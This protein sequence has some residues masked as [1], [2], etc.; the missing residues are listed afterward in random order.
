MRPLGLKN[1]RD[2]PSG[3]TPD[4]PVNWRRLIGYLRPFVLLVIVGLLASVGSSA[5]SLV[6]PRVIGFVVDSVLNMG[7]TVRL[8]QITL[9]LIGVFLLRAATSFVETLSILYIGERIVYNLRLELYKHLQSLSLGFFTERRTGEL[10]SRLSNDVNGIQGALTNNLSMGV[11]QSL[12]LIG[13]VV[14]M[15]GINWR[16]ALFILFLI[17]ILLVIG[18]VFGGVLRRL[19]SRVNDEIAGAF[20]V[21]TEVLTSIREV[22]SFVRE[23]FEIGR[24]G[25]SM[26]RAFRLAI[27]L[28]RIR[29][30]F[31]SLIAFLGFASIALVLW[32]GGREVI[33]GRLTGG[34]L[35]AFII[36]GTSVA[37]SLGSL[38]GLYSSFQE[39]L[40]ATKRVFEILDT[41]PNVN[42]APNATRLSTVEGRITF[43]TVSFSYDARQEALREINLDIAPGEIVALVGPSGAGKSTMFNLIP[44]FYDP[45]SGIVRI[46]G[47]DMRSVTQASLREQIAIVPQET[48]LFGGTIREN[49]LYGKLDATEEELIAA[50]TAANAHEFI[51]SFP[52]GYE[53]L[54]GERGIRLSGGQRQRVAIARALLKNPRILLLD[55]ATSSLDSE[56]E[57][58]V[59]EALAR[60]MQNRTT[61][62][63]AHRL[64]TVRVAHR[65]AVMDKG[66][67][68][69]LGTHDELMT[70]DGL[71]ARLY[72][73]QFRD[74]AED[75]TV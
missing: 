48:L 65:I 38:T 75:E 5:L 7:D 66:L 74:E 44:R 46:D 24:Y 68:V 54:V 21:V 60:L 28:L 63:I 57:H 67:I 59:Q 55:E 34:E 50:A 11:Q 2:N 13:S 8:D 1:D 45:S 56:S 6:F 30:A 53:S 40:G 36:Y 62:I 51:S 23:P 39:A 25:D 18:F 12:I 16:L 70:L 47:L 71:Y 3:E 20:V 42:D 19:S 49:I 72:A 61:V 26:T 17:P 58:E 22:K 33:D 41:P 64:S 29:A 27:R 52:D 35:I 69:E 14:L 73:M 37:S 10:L 31:G 4:V 15:I 9:L 32:F 43:E